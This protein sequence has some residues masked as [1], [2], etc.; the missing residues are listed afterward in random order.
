MSA[1][2]PALAPAQLSGQL[3]PGCRAQPPPAQPPGR[4]VALP[5]ARWLRKTRLF[6]VDGGD[7]G[8]PGH[9]DHPFGVLPQLQVPQGRVQQV[10]DH[11]IVDLMGQVGRGR[12]QMLMGG[13][14]QE[15]QAMARFSVPPESSRLLS[16][17]PWLRRETPSFLWGG[18]RGLQHPEGNIGLPEPRVQKASEPSGTPSAGWPGTG[19]G[20]GPDPWPSPICF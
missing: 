9:L 15:V 16:R 6:G 4:L 20:M 5:T 12:G 1:P 18:H 11:L 8:D 10:P 19:Q 14:G 2:A 3:L 13:Q 7:L 17:R